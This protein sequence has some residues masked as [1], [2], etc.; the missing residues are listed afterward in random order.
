M[1]GVYLG[2]E[3]LTFDAVAVLPLEEFLRRLHAGSVF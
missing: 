2:K 3:S 1:F